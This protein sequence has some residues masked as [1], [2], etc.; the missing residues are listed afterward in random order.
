[1]TK[2]S[3]KVRYISTIHPNFRDGLLKGNLKDIDE[4][5]SIFHTSLHQYYENRPISSD[6]KNV[7]YDEVEKE[8]NYWQNLSLAE[9][10]SD[11]E[12]VYGKV[13]RSKKRKSRIQTLLNGKGHIRRR[14]EPAVLRYF[15]SYDNDEDLT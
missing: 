11:Y 13:T 1:M 6:D 12:I 14:K 15:L 2:S 8:P 9:F 4:N 10:W 7:L 3:T 5:E